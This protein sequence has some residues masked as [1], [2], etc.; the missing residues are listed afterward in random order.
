[1][2]NMIVFA[3]ILFSRLTF[4]NFYKEITNNCRRIGSKQISVIC[5]MT[6]Q[7]AFTFYLLHNSLVNC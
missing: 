7:V 4:M 6:S 5:S 2:E 1:M 3:N